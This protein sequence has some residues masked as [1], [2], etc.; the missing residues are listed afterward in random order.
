MIDGG[1]VDDEHARAGI[2][3]R[4]SSARRTSRPGRPRRAGGARGRRPGRLVRAPP[5]SCRPSSPTLPRVG[6]ASGRHQER[7]SDRRRHQL[8]TRGCTERELEGG[9]LA[10]RERT[11]KAR[12]RQ[13]PEQDETVPGRRR[14]SSGSRIVERVDAHGA[15]GRE[16]DRPRPRARASAPYSPFGSSTAIWRPKAACRKQVGLHESALA[17]PDLAEHGDVRVGHRAAA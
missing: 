2:D 14:S 12:G 4:L 8:G 9:V 10:G 11:A 17:P 3:A 6:A 1:K 15:A 13:R 7:R 5:L 16:A